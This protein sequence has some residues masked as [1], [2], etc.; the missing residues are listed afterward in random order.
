MNFIGSQ[1]DT[2]A[3]LLE[4]PKE[5]TPKAWILFAHCFTCGKDIMSA[6]YISAAL[7]RNE[8]DRL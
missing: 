7:T 1:G 5:K 4:L 3:A 8:I 6:K 2:L